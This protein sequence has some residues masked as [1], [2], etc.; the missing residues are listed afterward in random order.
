MSIGSK[1]VS[2][3]LNLMLDKT[4]IV[5]LV[6]NKT[7]VGTLSSYE[8]T[9]FLIGL[10][11]A[12]D[13]ENNV[14]YKVVINGAHIQELLMKSAPI[15]DVKEFAELLVRSLGL[16]SS[17]IRIYEEAGIVVVLDKIKVSESGVEGSGPLA[18]K[19]FDVYNEYITK[20]KK[21]YGK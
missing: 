6:N 17:D 4:V 15:F 3:D 13:N 9:P 5:K 1:K 10:T 16:R 21:E 12:K 18:Q 20:K 2:V 19:V 7:Y 14:Y 11:N 8:L